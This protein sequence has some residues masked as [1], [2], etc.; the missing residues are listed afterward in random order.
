MAA[1]AATV[2][3]ESDQVYSATGA[4]AGAVSVGAHVRCRGTTKYVVHLSQGFM[5]ALDATLFYTLEP[6]D[7]YA[8]YTPRFVTLA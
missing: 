3:V 7:I 2:Q 5:A 6:V 8:S 4:I 1:A